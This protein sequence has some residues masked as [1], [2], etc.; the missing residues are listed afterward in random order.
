MERLTAA[1]L[2]EAAHAAAEESEAPEF[3]RST[4]ASLS[5]CEEVFELDAERLTVVLLSWLR[6]AALWREQ[7]LLAL[8]QETRPQEGAG[9]RR[10]AVRRHRGAGRR[11]AAPAPEPARHRAGGGGGEP[12]LPRG[13]KHRRPPGRRR[14]PPAAAAAPR[15]GAD[16]LGG[17]GCRG[18]WPEGPRRRQQRRAGLDPITSWPPSASRTPG[19]W[20]C[21]RS[22]TGPSG[23]RT[24]EGRRRS[25]TRVGDE[26]AKL[27]SA[28]AKAEP[29]RDRLKEQLAAAEAR[30]R[31]VEQE[32]AQLTK[33]KDQFGLQRKKLEAELSTKETRINRLTEEM[34]KQKA[35]LK[36]A[37]GADRDRA[38][39]DRRE[40][41]RLTGEVRKLERQ[42]AEL[43]AA[44][45]K[46]MKLIEVLKR[47]R[48]HMEAAKVLSFT[49]DEFIARAGLGDKLGE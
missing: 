49:E 16:D 47:Q 20:R 14:G 24:A 9:A 19:S 36:A 6:E 23:R 13:G 12:Q 41:D 45:K 1:T 46:Q 35:S 37:S 38:G 4:A 10:R 8:N 3:W 48:A 29:E 2:L 22:W 18:Q 28:Q 25:L 33:E 11:R 44:F 27:K 42:R 39:G 43:V 31:D 26:N 7:E 32:R 17:L 15:A 5:A 34:E 21:R 30:C 40:I